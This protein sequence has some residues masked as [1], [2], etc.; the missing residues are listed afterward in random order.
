MPASFSC[1]RTEARK[2]G[3]TTATI[4]IPIL[5]TRNISFS[6]TLAARLQMS[7]DRR[8]LPRLAP[9]D[10]VDVRREHARDVAGEAAT[11]DVGERLDGTLRTVSTKDRE[12]GSHVDARRPE[13]LLAERK[14]ATVDHLL[15]L[16]RARPAT[17][18]N[19][20]HQRV[21]VRVDSTRGD[22]NHLVAGP[23]ARAVDHAPLLDD[24]DG[25]A[26]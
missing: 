26:R 18:E 16:P 8:Y 3:E 24:A 14:L 11:G 19:L 12:E 2:C 9:H 13:E 15:Q 10:H 6:G 5:K 17:K 25:E 1:W 7:K 23:H 21:T 20:A 22:P 4:P